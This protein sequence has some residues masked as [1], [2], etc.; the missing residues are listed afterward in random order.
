MN[1]DK[2]TISVGN[3]GV[4]T[5]LQVVFLVLKL[6]GLVN[7]SWWFVFVPTIAGAILAVIL[8]TILYFVYYKK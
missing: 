3:G 6:A 1:K 8:L 4:L 2:T 5:T 7:W